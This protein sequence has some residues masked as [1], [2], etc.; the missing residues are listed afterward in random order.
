MDERLLTG[1][2]GRLFIVL[3]LGV[4]AIKIGRYLVPPLLPQIITDLGITAAEA[5]IA[6][7]VMSA[8]LALTQYPGGRLSDR[9]SRKTILVVSLGLLVTGF[10]LLVATPTYAVFVIAVAIVGAGDG[11]YSPASRA[12]LSD[13]FVERRGQAFGIH[14]A[15]I[16]IGG[17]V[18]AGVAIVVLALLT[19]RSSFILVI[20]LLVPALGILHW[21]SREPYVVKRVPIGIRETMRRIFGDSRIRWLV[22]AYALFVFTWQGVMSFLPTFLQTDHGFSPTIASATFAGLFLA[23]I[24]TKPVAGSLSDRM[25]RP[26]IAATGLAIA[27]AGITILIAAPVAWAAMMGVALYAIGHKSFGP[28]MAAYLMDLFPDGSMGGDLGAARTVYLGLASLGPAYVG[29]VAIEWNYTVAFIGLAVSLLAA[30]AI[31]LW[32]SLT[33]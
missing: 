1:Y 6:M 22:A 31:T 16:D 18:G 30:A 19:W 5:G 7:S 11:L 13:L 28:V 27:V 15:F 32:F 2:T 8:F 20:V 4:A 21:W 14:M 33:E 29:V 26:T 3:T 23:G 10:V 17:I 24:V 25:A 12:L 9:L